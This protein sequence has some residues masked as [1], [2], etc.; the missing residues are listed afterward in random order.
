M[1]TVNIYYSYGTLFLVKATCCD[2][3]IHCCPT[4]YKCNKRSSTCE[5]SGNT[6]SWFLLKPAKSATQQRQ[7]STPSKPISSDKHT[8]AAGVQMM[9]PVVQKKG[10][11][12]CPGGQVRNIRHD[13]SWGGG[14][15]SW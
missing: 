8:L 13:M 1:L 11:H 3:G 5:Q 10:R 2:D 15:I 14:E 4:G 6:N 7:V 12:V 9:K